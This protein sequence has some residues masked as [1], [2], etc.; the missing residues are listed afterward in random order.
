MQSDHVC[1]GCHRGAFQEAAQENQP[2]Q[3]PGN[4]VVTDQHGHRDVP[5]G[6]QEVSFAAFLRLKEGRDEWRDELEAM[7]PLE[8]Y[9]LPTKVAAILAVTA[10]APVESLERVA[11]PLMR[12]STWKANQ[13]ALVGPVVLAL[14]G[15]EHL[16]LRGTVVDTQL[17]VAICFGTEFMEFLAA[18]LLRCSTH[19]KE[20][21]AV[22]SK[23]RK[24]SLY[25]R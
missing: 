12:Y 16:G 14:A 23:L 5:T 4:I 18:F 22:L 20:V 13:L 11:R 6:T 10:G 24:S 9:E 1:G 3:G 19:S 2:L 25:G 7:S 8:A 21:A 15:F 17:E